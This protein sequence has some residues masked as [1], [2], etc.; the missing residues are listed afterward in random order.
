VPQTTF[1]ETTVEEAVM[2]WLHGL[3]YAVLQ[4]P[5]LPDLVSGKVHSGECLRMLK[6]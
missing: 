6:V 5:L 2:D 3:G 1:A 4:Y